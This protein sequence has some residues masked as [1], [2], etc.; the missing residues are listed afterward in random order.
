MSLLDVISRSKGWRDE[1]A[2][3]VVTAVS[4]SRAGDESMFVTVQEPYLRD[5]EVFQSPVSLE[6]ELMGDWEAI[7]RSMGKMPKLGSFW[8]RV[9]DYAAPDG[10]LPT[11]REKETT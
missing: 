4:H 2:S 5:G 9:V 8:M 10:N 1:M 3:W 7:G 11:W 6:L